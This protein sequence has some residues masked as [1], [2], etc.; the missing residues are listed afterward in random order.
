MSGHETATTIFGRFDADFHPHAVTAPRDRFECEVLLVRADWK[1]RED[2]AARRL[3]ILGE[4]L[5]LA[6]AVV[7]RVVDD[8][9][10]LVALLGQELRCQ[11]SFVDH[12]SVDAMDFLEVIPVRDLRQDRPHTRRPAG[13]SARTCRR[14]R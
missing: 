14:W 8:D 3:Q 4:I 6:F 13:R 11:L 2:L 1:G 9:E 5:E 7:R 10:L 12:R